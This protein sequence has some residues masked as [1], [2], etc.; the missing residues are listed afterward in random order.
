MKHCDVLYLK[1]SR[2]FLY[3]I[4]LEGKNVSSELLAWGGISMERANNIL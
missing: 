1:A 3:D 2:F 4:H